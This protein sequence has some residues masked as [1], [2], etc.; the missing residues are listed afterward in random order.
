MRLIRVHVEARLG[1]GSRVRIEGA[2]IE[3][4]PDG[5]ATRCEALRIEID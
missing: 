5:R 1:P 4:D 2:V 3:C